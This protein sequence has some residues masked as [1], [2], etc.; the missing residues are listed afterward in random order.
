[1]VHGADLAQ[2]CLRAGVLDELE[3]HLVPVLLGEGRRLFE[4][5]GAEHVELEL[6]RVVDAPGV[7]HLHYRVAS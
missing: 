5:L 6:T 4:H 3:I 1:M 7:T 2:S